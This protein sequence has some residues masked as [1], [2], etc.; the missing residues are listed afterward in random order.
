MFRNIQIVDLS[1]ENYM[2]LIDISTKIYDV[3]DGQVGLI[4]NYKENKNITIMIMIGKPCGAL[5]QN[6]P[7]TPGLKKSQGKLRCF[8]QNKNTLKSQRVLY[9][10]KKSKL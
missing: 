3:K 5:Q 9:L 7:V 10:G 8:N 4:I 2:E 6:S 1:L